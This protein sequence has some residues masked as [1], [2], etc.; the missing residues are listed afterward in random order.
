MPDT[1]SDIT[2]KSVTDEAEFLALK[3]LWNQSVS[4][5][6]PGKLFYRHEWFEA[7]RKW[8]RGSCSSFSLLVYRNNTLLG[9][10]P[11][12]LCTTNQGFYSYVSLGFMMT[13][14]S[15]YHDIICT[16][17]NRQTVLSSL[18]G[19]LESNEH[20]WDVID[21]RHL[22]KDS[23]TVQY[24]QRYD[25][26][27]QLNYIHKHTD[28]YSQVSLDNRWDTYY[29]QRSRHLKKNNNH[30]RNKL[31][32][33]GTIEVSKYSPS[34]L[35]QDEIAQL[36]SDVYRIASNSWKTGTINDL[37][38]HAGQ[39]YLQY[40]LH[41]PV[42]SDH[43]TVWMLRLDNKPVAYEIQVSEKQDVYA[44]HADFHNTYERLSP[45][46]YLNYAILKQLFD[47]DFKTYHMGSGGQLYKKAWETDCDELSQVLLYSSSI[48][49][50]TH[51]ISQK[52][53]SLL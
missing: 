2:V 27:G 29:K 9:I 31:E 15:P 1:H 14:S 26:R 8:H 49:A 37:S 6:L 22:R 42:L 32:K 12:M 13:P 19:F 43:L 51:K 30:A 41:Q 24:I 21:L 11:L 3:P 4:E 23:H 18:L 45:G 52:I 25:V 7:M 5:W 47:S 36:N 38:Q 44:L 33:M 39:E 28:Y 34:S 46:S 50:K 16:D 10:C 17:N 35:S 40:L 20:Q 48:K 53:R